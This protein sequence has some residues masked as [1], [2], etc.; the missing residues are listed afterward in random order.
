MIETFVRTFAAGLLPALYLWAGILLT[1][2][3]VVLLLRGQAPRVPLVVAS[4]AAACL[5]AG[6]AAPAFI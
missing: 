5:A 1:L 6:A 2:A 4:V 3:A